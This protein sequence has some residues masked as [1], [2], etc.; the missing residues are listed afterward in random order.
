MRI[1]NASLETSLAVEWRR[2]R[3]R[4]RSAARRLAGARRQFQI[5]KGKKEEVAGGKICRRSRAK[6]A[7]MAGVGACPNH[8]GCFCVLWSG[9]WFEPPEDAENNNLAA[10][11]RPRKSWKDRQENQAKVEPDNCLSRDVF[12]TDRPPKGVGRIGDGSPTEHRKKR[13]KKGKKNAK[14]G[15]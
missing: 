5:K 9:Q 13:K 6:A 2:R 10:I 12:E 8:T 11:D 1:F 15:R 7:V 4:E 3:I 14:K